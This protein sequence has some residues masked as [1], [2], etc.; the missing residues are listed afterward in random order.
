MRSGAYREIRGWHGR[1]FV[2]VVSTTKARLDATLLIHHPTGDAKT[3]TDNAGNPMTDR[4]DALHFWDDHGRR[5]VERMGLAPGALVLDVGCGAGAATLPAAQ[6][7]GQDGWVVGVDLSD[8]LLELARR[9]AARHGIENVTFLHQDMTALPFPEAHFDGVISNF[10]IYFADDVAGLIGQLW[11]MVKP[12]G[13]L[14]IATWAPPIFEPLDTLFRLCAEPE[15]PHLRRLPSSMDR[16]MHS[17]LLQQMMREADAIGALA[18]VEYGCHE[19]PHPDDWWNLVVGSGLRRIVET[20]NDEDLARVRERMTRWIG[21][22]SARHLATSVVYGVA[23]K[24]LQ[25]PMR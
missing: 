11:R 20:M 7:V 16:V 23:N 15:L 6:V 12:G 3:A 8:R 21:E 9:K 13:T 5:A 2:I 18:E 4:D 19:L 10:S 22:N 17:H 14:M 25:C 24:P 1:C